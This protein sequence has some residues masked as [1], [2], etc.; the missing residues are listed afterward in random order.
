MLDDLTI[1]ISPDSQPA[2]QVCYDETFKAYSYSQ[3]QWKLVGSSKNF[4]DLCCRCEAQGMRYDGATP[5]ALSRT[6]PRHGIP[7]IT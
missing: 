3:G 6:L 7:P 4:N 1:P 2:F 5:D